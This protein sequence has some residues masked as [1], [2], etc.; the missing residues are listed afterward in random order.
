MRI[1]FL[2]LFLLLALQARLQF[3]PSA[4]QAAST[5][6]A[7]DSSAF[8]DW[9][10]ACEIYRGW[11]NIADTSLGRVHYGQAEDA[12]GMADNKVVSLGDGGY[13][14]YHFDVPV[15]DGE[16]FD[17]AVF[18]NAFNDNFLELA[19]VEVSSDASHFYRFPAISLTQTNTQI[20]GFD[21]LEA[22]SLHCFAGK[23]RAFYGTPFDLSVMDTVE[24]LDIHH[25]IEVKIRDV[26]GSIEDLYATFDSQGNKVNDP[27]PTPFESGGFDLDAVGVIN[28]VEHLTVREEF[29]HHVRLYPN[30]AS[31]FIYISDLPD[32]LKK[33]KFYRWDMSLLLEK[34]CYEAELKVNLSPFSRGIYIV[35]VV[36]NRKQPVRFKV[37]LI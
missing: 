22:T 10:N 26:V 27:F 37:L 8:V 7:A 20:G 32:G 21:S 24:G 14:L 6:M 23:Y 31:D 36:G 29:H 11:K 17:I 13:A 16:G 2:F 3:A 35:E 33:I 9:A 5:A 19:F 25:I 1:L 28:D 15:V 18:E 30:P 12:C 34:E 4:G